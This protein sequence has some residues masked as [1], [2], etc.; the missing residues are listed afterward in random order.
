MV[1]PRVPK[2]W[3]F[4]RFLSHGASVGS[5]YSLVSWSIIKVT[6]TFTFHMGKVRLRYINLTVDENLRKKFFIFIALDKH[7]FFFSNIPLHE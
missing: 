1:L 5:K 3:C 7:F 4:N 6:T 2:T